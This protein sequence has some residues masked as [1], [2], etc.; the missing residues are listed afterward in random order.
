MRPS[1]RRRPRPMTRSRTE[2][3]PPEAKSVA[4][5]DHANEQDDDV[6]AEIDKVESGEKADEGAS[7]AERD[8][9]NDVTAVSGEPVDLSSPRTDDDK[10][11]VR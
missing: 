1:T 3:P 8:Q 2:P 11:P 9:E 4:P 7:P 10:D 6:T 5:D